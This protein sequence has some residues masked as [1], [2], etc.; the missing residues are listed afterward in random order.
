MNSKNHEHQKNNL[1]NVSKSSI[2]FLGLVALSFNTANAAKVFKLE[3][4][5][6]QEF[7]T[8]SVAN[9]QQESQ[10]VFANSSS[11]RIETATVI[12][13]PCSVIKTTYVKTTE[14]V[15]SENNLI[16]ENTEAEVQPLSL[17]LVL[18]NRIIEGNQI[19][20]STISNVNYPLDFEKI[21]HNLKRIKV[22]HNEAITADMK[23]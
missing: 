1:K 3:N 17:D 18:E 5:D 19:I 23:L 21:N 14:A 13:N 6:Q 9:N 20:E 12:F 11:S 22:S 2:I 16:T 7:A 8:F 10:I 15:I 4:L